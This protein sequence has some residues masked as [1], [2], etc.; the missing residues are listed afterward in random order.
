[1]GNWALRHAIQKYVNLNDRRLPRVFD[2]AFLMAADEDNDAMHQPQKLKPLEQLANRVFVYHARDDIALTISDV[3]KTNPDRLGSDGPQ[4]LDL[5]GNR[6]FTI[7]CV[8]VSGTGLRDGNHQYYRGRIEVIEDV[9]ATLADVPQ[10]GRKGR[11]DL[12][13]GRSW[14]L[15]KAGN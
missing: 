12:R 7:N 3:T 10:A 6:V 2:C 8:Q 11:K 5:V 13:P 9:R 14:E 15:I 1:M 4:N